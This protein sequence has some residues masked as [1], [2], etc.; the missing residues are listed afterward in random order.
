MQIVRQP[1]TGENK[2]HILIFAPDG[3]KTRKLTEDGEWITENQPVSKVLNDLCIR[4]GSTME[5]RQSAFRKLTGCRQKIP[6]LISERTQYMVFPTL[7]PSHA[8]C[9]W[10][11]CNDI[12]D[13]Q[14]ADEGSSVVVF[15]NGIRQRVPFGAR[16]LRR[17]IHRCEEF[18]TVLDRENPDPEINAKAL[19][20]MMLQKEE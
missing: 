20:K 2:L 19:L 13:I 18:L 10:I 9:M 7:S 1:V 11:S 5:G 4:N 14:A 16:L 6:V 12:L 17:Q 15:L 8:E 3:R